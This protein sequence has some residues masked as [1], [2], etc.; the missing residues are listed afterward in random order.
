MRVRTISVALGLTAVLVLTLLLGGIGQDTATGTGNGLFGDGSDGSKTYSTSET[1]A[2]K[3]AVVDSGLAGTT[4]LV[5]SGVGAG[6]VSGEKI[7]I[8]QT[9]G[10]AAG[11]WELNE[12]QSYAL[13]NI[14]TM[15]PLNNAYS[16][17]GPSDPERAQVYVVPEYT[18]FTVNV[19]VTVTAKA[20]DGSTGGIF[21]AMASGTATI[22]GV[23]IATGT[24]F[25][26]GQSVAKNNIGFY[27]EGISGAS[28]S[29]TGVEKYGNA[30]LASC[31]VRDGGGGGGGNGTSG[32]RGWYGAGQPGPS[33]GNTSGSTDLSL[34][35]FGGGGGGGS[36]GNQGPSGAGGAGGGFIF[37]GASSL[38]STGTVSADANSGQDTGGSTNSGA[39]GGGA[40]G[41]IL[42][43]FNSGSVGTSLVSA[44][45]GNGG[46]TGRGGN[47]GSGG[48]TLGGDGTYDGGGGAGGS[49]RIRVEYCT[50]VNGGIAN[51]PA[52]IAQI[53]CSIIPPGP[54][55]TKQPDPG[56]S[57]KD[58]C[59]DAQ[60]NGPDE[61]LGGQRDYKNPW[62]FYDVE[63]ISGPG[64]DGVV[65]LLF[66]ILG[67]I[68]HY[69][70][71]AG[72]APP[73]DAHYDRGESAGP[74]PWNMTAPDGVIDLLND[75]LGVVLQG[76][77][78]CT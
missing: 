77:H 54:T 10:T 13:G 27:G 18:D 64:E 33:G 16:T 15:S 69:Q 5:V 56:D 68:N 2:A 58:G 70:P 3:D 62:D 20:W 1:D 22:D 36:G 17:G 30:G 8:H 45:F 44:R 47:G 31:V 38:I 66:D 53:S 63:T 35:T 71:A 59:T 34:A 43:R 14:I 23:I 26:G 19:G 28:V 25:R 78:N 21:A 75:I 39:G 48:A 32:G 73:Y 49:G 41:S 37:I 61:T 52:S 11:S 42:L 57:D 60:E 9:R 29:C 7:L 74:N 46:T 50:K 72:G 55:P 51:P 4:T 6:F 65:D 67:V 76:N 40:G 24:G 12:V